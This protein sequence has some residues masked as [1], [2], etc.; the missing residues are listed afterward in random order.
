MP[1]IFS[2]CCSK[3]GQV[4]SSVVLRCFT[5]TTPVSTFKCLS[6][7]KLQVSMFKKNYDHVMKETYF[8]LYQEATRGNPNYF[9]TYGNGKAASRVQDNMRPNGA[10]RWHNYMKSPKWENKLPS[11]VPKFL[12]AEVQLK[13]ISMMHLRLLSSIIWCSGLYGKSVFSVVLL[14]ADTPRWG[15]LLRLGQ[16]A[17][18]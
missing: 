1:I 5:Q 3:E 12:I 2:V 4:K 10:H 9:L 16:E 11:F 7:Y 17:E 8:E 18:F 13:Q 6:L 14:A 15:L